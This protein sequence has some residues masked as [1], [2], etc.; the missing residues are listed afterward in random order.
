MTGR[1]NL[2]IRVALETTATNTTWSEE[3]GSGMPRALYAS[4]WLSL[5]A[6][7]STGLADLPGYVEDYGELPRVLPEGTFGVLMLVSG[8]LYLVLDTEEGTFGLSAGAPDEVDMG[9]IESDSLL[10]IATYPEG[11]AEGLMLSYGGVPSFISANGGINEVF[12]Y[13]GGLPDFLDPTGDLLDLLAANGAPL[14]LVDPDGTIVA[15]LLANGGLIGLMNGNGGLIGLMNGNGGL[16]GHM[17]GN[18]QVDAMSGTDGEPLPAIET[19]GGQGLILI[20]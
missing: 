12:E 11:G 1:S 15:E 14:L 20:Q 2:D 9:D 10:D 3:T 8:D 5:N 6:G 19:T 17:N 7:F 18:G 13:V 4:A 16:I